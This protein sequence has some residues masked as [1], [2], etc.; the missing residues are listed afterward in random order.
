MSQEGSDES[1]RWVAGGLKFFIVNGRLALPTLPGPSLTLKRSLGV[2]NL[3][4]RLSALSF[5][6]S[7]LLVI[8]ILFRTVYY[9]IGH[10]SNHLLPPHVL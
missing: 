1:G 10:V 3:R 9:L 2:V 4:F 6:K 5:A 7:R 8:P